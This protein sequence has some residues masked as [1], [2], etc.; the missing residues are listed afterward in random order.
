[1]DFNFFF[2]EDRGGGYGAIF[3]IFADTAYRFRCSKPQN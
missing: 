3:E 1:M 2:L